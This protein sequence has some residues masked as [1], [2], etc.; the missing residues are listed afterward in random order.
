MAYICSF[1]SQCFLSWKVNSILCAFSVYG[2]LTYIILPYWHKMFWNG[3]KST[4]SKHFSALIF[5]RTTTIIY[6]LCHH[7]CT[8]I[9]LDTCQKHSWITGSFKLKKTLKI[10]EFKWK[11]LDALCNMYSSLSLKSFLHSSHK[12]METQV[13][14]KQKGKHFLCTWHS[15]KFRER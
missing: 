5:H 4:I 8:Q 7:R 1:C 12:T 2:P 15:Q 11:S 14:G 9:V 6:S 13:E 10:I 3:P